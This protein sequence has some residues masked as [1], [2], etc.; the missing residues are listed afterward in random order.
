MDMFLSFDLRTTPRIFN[1]FAEALY[2]IFEILY[3]W[4]VTHY[5]DDFLFMFPPKIDITIVFTQFDDVLTKFGLTKAI[6][7]DSDDCVVVHLEFE[8]DSER[9]QVR[10]S[11]NKK[12]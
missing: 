2:R 5:L 7:K 8:F 12:Q 4:N 6:E 1:L 11:S 9:M 10:L 3:E